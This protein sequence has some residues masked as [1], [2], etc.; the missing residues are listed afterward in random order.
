MNPNYGLYQLRSKLDEMEQNLNLDKIL[1]GEKNS[2]SQIKSYFRINN[3][4]YRR[5]HSQDGFMHFRVSPNGCF[6]D[7]D[8]YYQPDCV[9]EFIKSGD[10]VLELGFGQGAN[11]LYLARCH[12]DA[13]FVGLD[14]LPLKKSKDI[15]PNVTTY[16]Q[17][18]SDLSQFKDKSVDVMFAFETIVHNSDKERIYR[19]VYRVL[20]P[21]GV[22]VVFDYA[23]NKRYETYDV[24]LKKAI[25]LVSKGGA[26]AIIESFEELN[27]IYDRCGLKVERCMDLTRYTLPDLKRLERKAAKIMNRPMLSKLM[28]WLLPEQFVSNIV[29]GYLGYDGGVAGLGTYREWVLRK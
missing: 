13:T 3:W 23:L 16:Q 11:L 21:G 12:P 6:T 28:F 25:A 8:V 26:S 14:L 18:Y 19:E 9:S 17:D 4:A 29:L 20:K 24:Y 7:E 15:P 27:A 22:M 5:F 10:F 2:I 1:E